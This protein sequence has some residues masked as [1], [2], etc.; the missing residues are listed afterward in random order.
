MKRRG[1]SSK[2]NGKQQCNA[3]GCS[4]SCRVKEQNLFESKPKLEDYHDMNSTNY[5]VWMDINVIP[6]ISLG[7]IAVMHH[8]TQYKRV[9]LPILHLIWL[10]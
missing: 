7:G 3:E 9:N 5:W 2:H 1:F 4:C 6:I 8:I 10:T